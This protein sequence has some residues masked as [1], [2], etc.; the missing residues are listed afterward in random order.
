M[1]F[2]FYHLRLLRECWK[3]SSQAPRKFNHN[4]FTPPN[5]NLKS[6]FFWRQK[7]GNK[8]LIRKIA[9]L[10]RRQIKFV[11]FP[12][13]SFFFCLREPDAPRSTSAKRRSPS[14]AL[15]LIG[16]RSVSLLFTPDSLAV[17]SFQLYLSLAG[18]AI[19]VLCAL[20]CWH[21]VRQVICKSPRLS[22]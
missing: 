2:L 16:V 3:I 14:G 4:H 12:A 11:S 18:H 22:E 21:C 7:G 6:F 5:L 17:C 1:E 13:L 8:K 19:R 20:C 9:A 15:L 10:E